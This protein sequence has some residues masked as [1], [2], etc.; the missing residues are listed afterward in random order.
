MVDGGG[1]PGSRPWTFKTPEN[2]GSELW[3][4]V[5]CEYQLR[6]CDNHQEGGIALPFFNS[7]WC[8]ARK[9]LLRKYNMEG[10][11]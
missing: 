8:S 3:T 7:F 4:S 10:K 1:N 5:D 9:T 6:K 11:F 2:P